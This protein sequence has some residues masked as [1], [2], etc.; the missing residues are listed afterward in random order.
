MPRTS[1]VQTQSTKST[2][3]NQAAPIEKERTEF[4]CSRCKRH[5][6]RQKGNFPASQS[7]L[8]DGNG[9]YLTICNH[10][11]DE[12]FEHYKA[13]L[14]NEAD[15]IHRICLK[16]DIYWNPEIYAM[17]SKTN[18]SQSRIRAYI[19]KSNLWKYIGKTYDDTLDEEYAAKIEAGTPTMNVADIYEKKSSS[20]EDAEEES[21]VVPEETVRYWGTGFVPKVYIELEER[22]DYWMS[23]FPKGTVLDPGEEALLRQIC[24]LEININKDLTAGNPIEKGIS[25]LNT[26]LGSMNI[27]P[28]QKK[29][30]EDNAV[31]FGCEIAKFEEENPIPEPDPEFEDVDGIRKKIMA[32]FLGP[33]C[34]TVG[35]KNKY[36]KYFDEEI[37]KYTVEKPEYDDEDDNFFDNVEINKESTDSE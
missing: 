6:R 19:S 5:F 30:A 7:P 13:A 28:S 14:E 26:L 36:N 21:I 29:E 22:R 25:A 34:K 27:K 37:K 32:W 4:Y 15:A 20:A 12:L 17:L 10:C 2:K 24:I 35:V 31:P 8:Y 1:K 9:K 16:F 3:P 11:V 23:Q 18:T 33:L